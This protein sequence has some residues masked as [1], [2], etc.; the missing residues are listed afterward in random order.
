MFVHVVGQHPDM[1]VRQQH[2][3]QPAQLLGRVGGARRVGRRVEHQPLRARRDRA[4]EVLRAQLVAMLQLGLDG[5]RRA[6]AEKH[7]V[8]I[9]HPVGRRHDDLV[10]GVQRGDH[11]VVEHRLAARRD[12]DLRRLVAQGVVALEL[13]ADRLLQLRNA[14]DG[15]VLGLA[16]ADRV[17]G[18]GLDIVRRVEIRLAGAEPDHVAPRGLQFTRLRRHRDGGGG[19]DPLEGVGEEGHGQ[20]SPG[21]FDAMRGVL[22]DAKRGSR[23]AGPACR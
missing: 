12:M 4:G 9:G 1:R 19:L 10:A 13:G 23:R 21:I 6:A 2:V 20:M 17:D 8:G 14:V 5:D 16:P 15:G 7:D 18:G 3:C 11:R 22:V